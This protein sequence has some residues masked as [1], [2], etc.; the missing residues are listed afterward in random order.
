MRN[1]I[2]NALAAFLFLLVSLTG[3]QAAG[4]AMAKGL[5]PET[6]TTVLALHIEHSLAKD[7]SGNAIIEGTEC[8]TPKMFFDAI[9]Q[10]HPNSRL[11]SVGNCGLSPHAPSQEGRSGGYLPDGTHHP[12]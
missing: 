7:K 12:A 11:G 6:A 8:S 5:P 9:R 4:L 1:M 2:V 10:T 3:A